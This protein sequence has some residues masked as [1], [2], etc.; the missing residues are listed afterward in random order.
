[1]NIKDQCKESYAKHK[2]LRLVGLELGIPWQ[3]VYVHLKSIGVMVTGDKSRYGTL[4]DKFAA[5]SEGDFKSLVPCAE[6]QNAVKHQ[7]SV[8]FIV[9]GIKVDIKAS[10]LNTSNKGSKVRRWAFSIKKQNLKADFLVCMAYKDDSVFKVLLIPG[11]LVRGK[12]TIS[13][14][15]RGSKWDDYIIPQSD[16]AEFFE[17]MNAAINAA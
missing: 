4:K 12:A 3:T 7:A 15:E 10:T 14:S 5:R 17:S 6:D 9:H 8:D 2:K 13:V 16:L 1:M 11:E